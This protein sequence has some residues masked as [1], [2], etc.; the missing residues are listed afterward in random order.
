M[1]LSDFDYDLPQKLIAQAPLEERTASRLLVM[2]RHNGDIHDQHFSDILDLIKP[3]DLLVFNNTKLIPARLYGRKQTG[4][5]VELLLERLITE[6]QALAHIK[7][8]KAPRIGSMLIL[9]GDVQV[10]IIEKNAGLYTI[11]FNCNTLL[12]YLDQYG[13]I[14]L[15]PYINR[16]DKNEDKERYQTVFAKHPGAVAAPTAG[17]HF[18]TN[19]LNRIT[20]KGVKTAYV[21]L[22][23]GAGT[24]Q[25]VRNNDLSK[26]IM[27]AE[28]VDV[29]QTVVDAVI[30]CRKRGGKVF[31]VGTTSV[32]SLEAAS[33]TG[34][35]CRFSGDTRLFIT[36]GY[37]FKSVDA[38][39]TNF[40]LPLSTL[41]MLVSAF[42]SQKNILAAY[43]HAVNNEYRFFSYGDAMLL[44]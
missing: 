19:L 43:N 33:Q 12:D 36:P 38:I 3:E 30:D 35:L 34:N 6:N 31:A 15:P 28:Y 16:E 37:E 10:E 40:H 17:L 27:H 20:D 25:P 5:K 44:I 29:P 13:H 32:R 9:D 23:V 11:K 1:K 7:A 2:D 8:N 22:H 21:T 18:D 24:F 42:S 4:G 39:V 14:P 26:H 41:L